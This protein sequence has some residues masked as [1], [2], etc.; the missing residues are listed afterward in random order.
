[1]AK[2]TGPEEKTPRRVNKVALGIGLGMVGVIIAAVYF[3]FYFVEQE[4]QRAMLEW[5]VRLGIVADSR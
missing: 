3:T 5:Q 1:M 4:R 2:S